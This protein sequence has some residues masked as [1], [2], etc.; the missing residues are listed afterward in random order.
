MR[1]Q[2]CDGRDP[3]YFKGILKQR[4][5]K[6]HLS[7]G[8]VVH[9]DGRATGQCDIDITTGIHDQSHTHIKDEIHERVR[10]PS[11]EASTSLV[12]EE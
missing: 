1:M 7:A 11:H 2:D 9:E 5:I 12:E 10:I 3:L 6:V 4:G 8:E